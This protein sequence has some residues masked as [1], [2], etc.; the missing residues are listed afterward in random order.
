ME[1]S[2]GVLCR[3]CAEENSHLRPLDS[4]KISALFPHIMSEETQLSAVSCLTCSSKVDDY[5]EFHEAVMAADV[6][7]KNFITAVKELQIPE[8]GE[9]QLK[10]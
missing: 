8:D 9:S 2:L 4:V 7:L 5:F 10:G 6:K 1:I 3:L